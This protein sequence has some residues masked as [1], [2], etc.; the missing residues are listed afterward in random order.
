MSKQPCIYPNYSRLLI[1][2][3]Y[4]TY[5]TAWGNLKHVFILNYW[6]NIRDDHVQAVGR[7]YTLELP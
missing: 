6:N 2:R 7:K 3:K 4:T 5:F 1:N